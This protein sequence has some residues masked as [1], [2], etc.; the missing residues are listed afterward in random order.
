MNLHQ[1]LFDL[2]VVSLLAALTPLVVGL[3]SRL[4]IPQ[5]VVLIV[6]GILVGPQ[7]LGWA[8]PANIELISNLGLGFLFLLA[9]YELD[10]GLFRERAGRLAITSWLVTAV[11][12]VA[13][14]GALAATGFVEAFVPIAIG[15]TTTALGTLLPILRDNRMLEGR[16]GAFIM[17][18]GAVGEFLP[19]V[20]VAIFLSANGAFLG[21]IS[22]AV[23]AVIALLF[24]LVP[25]LVHPQ[26]LSAIIAQG[27]HA[28][29]QTTL[30]WTMF[31]LFA[32]LLVAADFGLDV[33][34]GAFLAGVVLRRWAPG[35]TEALEAKLDAVGYGFFI[36]VFFVS[37]GMSLD[38]RSII[39]APARLLV[40]FALFVVVRGLPALLFYRHE[41]P[42][43]GRVQMMLLTATALPLLVALAAIGLEAGTMLP[44]NAAALVGAGVLSVIVFPAL[45]VG[46]NRSTERPLVE[47]AARGD[48]S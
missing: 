34:L 39:E 40:F 8:E 17:A 2:A 20:A 15:L 16:F 27:E 21:L 48:A 37:S 7:V 10:L 42:M 45:A 30:R 36:P 47:P 9:G 5:V 22:L 11:I 33:V 3:L 28:T 6:G 25:R 4:R 18:A 23:V 35:D 43:R 13:V 19:I 46:L 1:G 29:S 26:K 24:T 41:L 14:T 32:L 38:L 31:L 44:E 12:A